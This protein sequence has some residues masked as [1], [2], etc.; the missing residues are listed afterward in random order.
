[1]GEGWTRREVGPEYGM[2]S[3]GWLITITPRC[4]S[5]VHYMEG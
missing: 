1:M 3:W 4:A 2:E 5:H